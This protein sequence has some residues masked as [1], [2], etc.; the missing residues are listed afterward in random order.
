[1]PTIT[2]ANPKGGSGKTTSALLLAT[3]LAANGA[4]VAII[5]ADPEQWITQWSQRP[6]LPD[7]IALT[8]AVS[9]TTIFDAIETAQASAQFVIVDLEGTASMMAANAIDGSDLVL[10]PVQGSSMDARGGAKTIS[11]IKLRSKILKRPIPHCVV[12]TRT[13]AA[14]TSRSL[15]NIQ[16]QLDL[17]GIDVMQTS[18]VE[19]AAYRDL[20][21][22]GGDLRSLKSTTVSNLDKAR[23][24]A[25]EFAGEVLAKLK[26]IAE[27]DTAA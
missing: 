7:R 25:R 14:V 18:I 3:E 15:R 19:R 10:I 26:I 8:S 17:A 16:E 6:G 20:L 1:M 23:A 13:S 5:D 12:L 21:D 22:F 9:E 11:L 2:F 24:N 27:Q 4:E